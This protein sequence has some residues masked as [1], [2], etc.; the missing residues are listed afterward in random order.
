MGPLDGDAGLAPVLP[1]DVPINHEM[2]DGEVPTESGAKSTEATEGPSMASPRLIP[3]PGPPTNSGGPALPPIMGNSGNTS[4]SLGKRSA[5]SLAPECASGNYD[6]LP[7]EQVRNLRKPRGYHKKDAKVVLKTRME[8]TGAAAR[9][10]SKPNENDMDATSSAMGT[11]DRSMAEPS[12][13]EGSTQV[14][15]G[16]R[17]RGDTPATTLAADLTAV[18]GHAQWGSPD[19]KPKIE[20]RQSSAVEGADGAISVRVADERNR[21]LG[22]E[23][24]PEEEEVRAD[25]VEAGKLRELEAWENFNVFSPQ[26]AYEKTQIAQAR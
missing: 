13:I 26:E 10:S 6:H 9:R 19:L 12:N 14:V 5:P 11:R 16:K 8:A 2:G 3:V 7:Y 23:L 20:A 18:H 15:A 1:E 17:S 24:T 21:I 25:L 22:Q 4:V